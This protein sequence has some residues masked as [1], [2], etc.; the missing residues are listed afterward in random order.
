M[1]ILL[2]LLALLLGGCT[3]TEKPTTI[4][5]EQAHGAL[6]EVLRLARSALDGSALGSL[7]LSALLT[8][9]QAHILDLDEIPL[10]RQRLELW[11]SAVNEAYR[12]TTRLMGEQLEALLDSL[13]IEDAR[14]VVLSTRISATSLLKEQKSA[15]ITEA[16][17]ALLSLALEESRGIWD[18]LHERYEIWSRSRALLEKETLPPLTGDPFEQLL[19]RFVDGY[20]LELEREEMLLRT[21]PVVKGSGSILEVF[22]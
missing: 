13:V 14:Q 20:L 3:T 5:E 7:P 15:E 16:A 21:T 1:R 10:L 6:V 8:E 19:T 18:T 9:E 12:S 4:T 2:L 11:G 22:Q 17:A